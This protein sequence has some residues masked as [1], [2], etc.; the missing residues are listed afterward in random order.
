MRISDWSSDVCAS[1]LS[2]GRGTV[3]EAN[4]GGEIRR[5]CPIPLHQPSAGPPPYLSMGR[6]RIGLPDPKPALAPVRAAGVAAAARAAHEIGRASC[7]E[8]VCQYV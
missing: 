6:N 2:V 7:G 3:R 4:G 8:R 5:S 1:D